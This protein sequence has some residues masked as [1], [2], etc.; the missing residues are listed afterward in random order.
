[1]V[2][3]AQGKSSKV[4]GGFFVGVG[5]TETDVL[6]ALYGGPVGWAIKVTGNDL[7]MCDCLEGLCE[8]VSRLD[9]GVGMEL[10]V[11][12]VNVKEGASVVILEL[13]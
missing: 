5:R 11:E 9:L 10:E 1:M 6:E 13:D 7:G 2:E 8:K 4:K 3:G 12:I